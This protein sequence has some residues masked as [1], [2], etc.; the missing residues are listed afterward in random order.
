[1]GTKKTDYELAMSHKYVTEHGR[2]PAESVTS[3][4]SLL[5]KPAL[6][7]SSAEIAAHFTYEA[8]LQDK[9][10]E[11]ANSVQPYALVKNKD[12]EKVKATQATLE[13][14]FLHAC[15]GVFKKK[16]DEKANLGSRIH[17]HAL[18][19][20]LG[21]DANVLEDEISWMKGVEKFFVDFEPKFLF[22]EEVVVNPSPLGEDA[23]EYGG[24][25]DAIVEMEG[26]TY[27]I[28]YKTGSP[29]YPVAKALQGAA[30]A[31]CQIAVYDEEGN[32]SH[33][34]P[35]PKL[36]GLRT[37]YFNIEGN[38]AIENPF[39]GESG[40]TTIEQSYESFINLKRVRN[41]IKSFSKN[42]L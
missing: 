30:Y 1:M 22:V 15:R 27:L 10:E 39:E 3:I 29:G 9:I 4:I 34:L 2:K 6:M 12:G 26:N 38:Y 35:L 37:V 31:N 11:V 13:E 16:W 7:W 21:K 19:W 23:L 17:D 20:A 42:E 32:L 25:F 14:R 28:D 18:N 24:R 33:T 8:V 5:D 40:L 36:D 41:W